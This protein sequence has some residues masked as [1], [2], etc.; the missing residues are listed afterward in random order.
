MTQHDPDRRFRA[1]LERARA[2]WSEVDLYAAAMHSAC[3]L[4]PAT[5]G[6]RSGAVTVPL[7]G[8]T[9]RVTHPG[10]EVTAQDTGKLAHVSLAILLLHYLLKADGT[11]PADRWVA[12]RELP[13]GLF[14]AQAFAGHAEAVI[15]QAFG[16]DLDAFASAARHLAG[17]PLDL[18]DASF[19]FEALPRLPMA[20]LVWEG[21]DEFPGRAR[22][23]FDANASHCLP[24]EDLSGLGDWLAHRLVRHR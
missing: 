15:A 22:V 14:Y 9:H 5:G 21:D 2:E 24:T 18:A 12:F 17:T 11:R 23:L 7:F 3:Q 8:R 20:V 13:D 6:D 19:R 16:S 10:G 4:S 1:A